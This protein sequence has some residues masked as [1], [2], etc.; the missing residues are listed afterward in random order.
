MLGATYPSLVSA[1][2]T[3]EGFGI[4]G[5]I[6]TLANNPGDIVYGSWAINHGATGYLTASGG[7]QIAVFPDL[8]TGNAAAN[9]LID[10]NYAGGSI[11]DLASKWLSGSSPTDISNWINNLGLDPNA[12]VSSYADLGEGSGPTY[13]LASMF[14]F[15]DPAS[16][17]FT[18]N[19]VVGD[20]VAGYR[21]TG[22]LLI[23]LAL[24]VG[25]MVIEKL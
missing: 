13:D 22:F 18:S 2:G 14:G 25:V 16:T 23:G 3:A 12:S 21:L 6:P 17:D 4:P 20:T 11:T 10:N 24:F 15:P 1:I 19:P 9:S 7:Q 5:A 8:A